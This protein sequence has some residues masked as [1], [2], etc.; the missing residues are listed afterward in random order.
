MTGEF[1][2]GH[3]ERRYYQEE[4]RQDGSHAQCALYHLRHLDEVEL[5]LYQGMTVEISAQK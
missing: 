5:D 1:P 3:R 2:Q 4:T